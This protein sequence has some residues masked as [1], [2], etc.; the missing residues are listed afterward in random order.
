MLI[1]FFQ[2]LRKKGNLG[3]AFTV[4]IIIIIILGLS[5]LVLETVN[6]KDI[7]AC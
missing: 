5:E 4:I 3:T 1:R 7:S 2:F 6:V